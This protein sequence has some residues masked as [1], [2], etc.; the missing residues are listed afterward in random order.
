MN[1]V[2]IE[3]LNDSSRDLIFNY[4]IV[5][6]AYAKT[7]GGLLLVRPRVLGEKA[8]TVIDL[9]ERAYDYETEGPSLQVDDIEIALPAGVAL[10]EL[11]GRGQSQ[12]RRLH[13]TAAKRNS[14]SVLHYRREYRVESSASR[15]AE[16]AE[17][18]RVFSAI[19]A[20]E[21]SSAVLKNSSTG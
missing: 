12:R 16:L 21:R 2:T 6:P 17:L 10:D 11:P 9:K 7:A 8:E 1:G 5:A 4:G 18:N 15:C 20:D 14:R 19:M 3:N 13:A